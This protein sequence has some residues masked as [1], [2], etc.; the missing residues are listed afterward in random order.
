MLCCVCCGIEAFQAECTMLKE[1]KTVVRVGVG[2]LL[3][4][5]KHPDCVL[6]GKRKGSHGQG[7]FALPGGHL[8]MYESW[9]ECA[10]REVKEE[11]GTYTDVLP[12]TRAR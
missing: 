12:Q 7:R 3:L 2:V 11:T 1:Q 6:I 4:S 8:E 9:E 5:L 10:I